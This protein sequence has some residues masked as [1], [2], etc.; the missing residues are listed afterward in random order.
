MNDVVPTTLVPFKLQ[1]KT[2]TS[3][4]NTP[5]GHRL[6]TVS[7]KETKQV[8]EK[9][10]KVRAACC[11]AIPTVTVQVVPD[12]LASALNECVAGFQDSIVA[13]IVNNAL[14]L[15]SSVQWNA[16]P[17]TADMVS[18]QGIADWTAA[19]AEKG[20]LSKDSIGNWFDTMLAK[21]LESAIAQVI[22]DGTENSDDILIAAIKAHRDNLQSLASPRANMPEK[23]V[24]QLQKALKLV[25]SDDKVK[26]GLS[27]RLASFIRPPVEAM[28]FGLSD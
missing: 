4:K 13:E 28:E 22:P 7:W 6:V 10:D 23:L 2:E 17:I 27:A 21:P 14:K 9:G 1:T 19:Q 24:K 11:V 20:R 15:D 18:L 3:E 26:A 12:L 25:E 5:A 16:I 8:K